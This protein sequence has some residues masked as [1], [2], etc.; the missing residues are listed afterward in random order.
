MFVPILVQAT[1]GKAAS[2]VTDDLPVLSLQ[3]TYQYYYYVLVFKTWLS[4]SLCDFG[5]V[6][7]TSQ[8]SLLETLYVVFIGG[9]W[10]LSM[11]STNKSIFRSKNTAIESRIKA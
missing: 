5:L 6:F 10:R 2:C 3:Y 1:E 4:A 7:E 9:Y 8:G 11:A